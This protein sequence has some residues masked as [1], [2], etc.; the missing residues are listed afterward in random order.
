[1]ASDMYDVEGYFRGED[2]KKN[3]RCYT[4]H[5]HE[6]KS[7]SEIQETL[8]S[9]KVNK[10]QLQNY[11]SY[12]EALELKFSTILITEEKEGLVNW[13]LKSDLSLVRKLRE[14]INQLIKG[15][16]IPLSRAS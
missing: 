15:V 5:Y 4:L 10:E 13:A 16:K 11:R 12:L 7:L 2:I 3:E 8:R 14:E 1:M 9:G 6:T